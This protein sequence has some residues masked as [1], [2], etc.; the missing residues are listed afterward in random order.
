MNAGQGQPVVTLRPSRWRFLWLLLVSLGFVLMGAA[1][2]RQG[3]TLV[4]WSNIIFFGLCAV[5]FTAN[6]LP[7]ASYLR[8]EADGFVLCSLFRKHRIA[9]RDVTGFRPARIGVSLFVGFD[10]RDEVPAGRRVRGINKRL[11][12]IE[13][14]LPDRYGMSIDGL[15]ELMNARREAALG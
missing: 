4:G 1:L 5:A 12:G 2:V 3:D 9:W 14:M 8:L 10:Y 11:T 13:G 7:N 15:V 6:L